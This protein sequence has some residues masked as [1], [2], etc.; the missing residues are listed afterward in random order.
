MTGRYR[1]A[2]VSRATIDYLPSCSKSAALLKGEK[3]AHLFFARWQKNRC[4]PFILFIPSPARI[5]DNADVIA[6]ELTPSL[7]P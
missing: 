1:F 6:F 7:P 2:V 4:V 5:N 3:V